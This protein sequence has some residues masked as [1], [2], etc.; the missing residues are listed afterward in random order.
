MQRG[1]LYIIILFLLLFAVCFYWLYSIEK[2][3]VV[4][5]DA[6]E[7]F[8]E[9]QFKKD[10][11][12]TSESKLIQ[13]KNE[14]DSL[15][16]Y[17]KSDTANREVLRVIQRKEAEASELYSRINDNINKQVWD[18]LNPLIQEYGKENNIKL[19]IGANGMGTVLYASDKRNVTKELINYINAKYAGKK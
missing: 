2:K 16:I 8:N 5:A 3:Q 19:L 18:R 15:V 13:M 14:L 7:L 6:I 1:L 10:L 4:Y 9:Y 17:Y 12:Q 11:E